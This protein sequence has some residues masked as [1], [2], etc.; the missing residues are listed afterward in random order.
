MFYSAGQGKTLRQ[1]QGRL[2]LAD[3][4]PGYQGEFGPGVRSMVIIFAFACQITEPKILEWL[5]QVGIQ[6]S[7]G[8]ISNLL[9]KDQH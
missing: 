1:A 7:A 8:Q 9:I 3:L 5:R 4:P 6:I 2:Y